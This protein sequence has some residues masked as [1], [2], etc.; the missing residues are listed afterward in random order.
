[1][2]KSR[3]ADRKGWIKPTKERMEV[4]PY[5]LPMIYYSTANAVAEYF[6][7]SKEAMLKKSRKKA[8]CQA[9]QIAMFLDHH[10][11]KE[12][13]GQA[14]WTEI[15]KTFDCGHANVIHAVRAVEGD[16]LYADYRDMLYKLQVKIFNE[17]RY[18]IEK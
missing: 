10:F 16:A 8:L 1:M 5:T 2:R 4:E 15:G 9:R 6:G 17:V 18:K 13:T 11:I 14:G 7:M 12:M 3:I